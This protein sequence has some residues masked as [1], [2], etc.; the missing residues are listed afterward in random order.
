MTRWKVE[1]IAQHSD[2]KIVDVDGNAI[3]AIYKNSGTHEEL[4]ARAKQIVR[5]HNRAEAVGAMR[6]ALAGLVHENSS[7]YA[8]TSD[9]W[10]AGKAA[11]AQYEQAGKEAPCSAAN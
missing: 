3:V 6:E 2:L 9:L 7:G 1:G 8:P 4:D 10:N 5:D 11:L